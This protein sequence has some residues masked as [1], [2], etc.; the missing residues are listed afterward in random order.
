MT[1]VLDRDSDI[2]QEI[3]R[4]EALIVD[5]D[6]R[7]AEYESLISG[8]MM[9]A[10]CTGVTAFAGLVLLIT[11][12]A[13]VGVGLILGGVGG[14]IGAGIAADK[15]E[16]PLKAAREEKTNYQDQLKQLVKTK[17]DLEQVHIM[18]ADVNSNWDTITNGLSTISLVWGHFTSSLVAIEA[19]FND[20]H[21]DLSVRK[22]IPASY[23]WDL[24]LLQSGYV[25]LAQML[26]QW[27]ANV[28]AI[29]SPEAPPPPYKA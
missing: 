16:H 20:L 10:I 13:P 26:D 28:V 18:L 15:W 23:L 6:K 7:I 9:S 3:K 25:V 19:S 27:S 2:K 14:T 8:C 17:T 12:L 22:V 5:V 4:I 21:G 24:K 11:P 29:Y 1:S